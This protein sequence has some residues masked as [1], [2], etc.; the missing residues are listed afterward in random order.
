M[1]LDVL[2]V[3]VAVVSPDGYS[4]TSGGVELAES[5]WVGTDLGSG[6]V[7]LDTIGGEA[8]LVGWLDEGDESK[9]RPLLEMPSGVTIT[10]KTSAW[11]MEVADPKTGTVR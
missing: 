1:D 9:A 4:L 7:V 11:R 8:H 2:P 6:R 5:T 10:P 3:A